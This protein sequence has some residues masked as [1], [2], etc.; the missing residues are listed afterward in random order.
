MKKFEKYIGLF[1]VLSALILFFIIIKLDQENNKKQEIIDSLT[2]LKGFYAKPQLEPLYGVENS[3]VYAEKEYPGKVNPL[4]G[5]YAEIDEELFI[6]ID[7]ML[8]VTTKSFKIYCSVYNNYFE[9]SHFLCPISEFELG[10][11]LNNIE[12]KLYDFEEWFPA[13]LKC[14]LSLIYKN[15]DI[16]IYY[17]PD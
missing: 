3:A 12:F 9:Y 11:N 13:A 10:F 7:T 17:Y 5:Y 4:N 8:S 6:E 2:P 16:R 1:I 15:K 14:S